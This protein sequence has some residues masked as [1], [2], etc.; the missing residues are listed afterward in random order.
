M[1]NQLELYFNTLSLSG[2]A[3]TARKERIGGQ[4]KKVLDYFQKRPEGYYTPFDVQI[5][6]IIET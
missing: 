2:P 1:N 4:N 6:K 5:G 3:L